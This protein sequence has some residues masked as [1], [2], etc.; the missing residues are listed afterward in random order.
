MI[1]LDSAAAQQFA[2]AAGDI[3][4]F[5]RV[6]KKFKMPRGNSGS[7]LSRKKEGRGGATLSRR[8]RIPRA[9]L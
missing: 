6:E 1:Q 8:E 3:L 5:P 7:E 2:Q 9:A 4:R